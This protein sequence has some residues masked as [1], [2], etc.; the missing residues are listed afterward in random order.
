MKCRTH[1]LVTIDKISFHFLALVYIAILNFI[2]PLL[3][4]IR[5]LFLFSCIIR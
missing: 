4:S 1:I 5:P 3:Y 2:V